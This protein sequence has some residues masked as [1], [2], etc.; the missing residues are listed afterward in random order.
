MS[1]FL[2][3][4]SKATIIGPTAFF[5]SFFIMLLPSEGI[6]IVAVTFRGVLVV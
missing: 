4:D 2:S 1:Y 6:A 3:W 5:N